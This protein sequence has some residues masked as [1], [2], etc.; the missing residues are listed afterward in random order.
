MFY[1]GEWEAQRPL[2]LDVDVDD[3]DLWRLAEDD[4]DFGR[5]GEADFALFCLDKDDDVFCAADKDI[6]FSTRV[7]DGGRWILD[8]TDDDFPSCGEKDDAPDFAGDND[9][10]F[11][12]EETKKFSGLPEGI[13]SLIAGDCFPCFESSPILIPLI[14]RFLLEN[15]F[16]ETLFLLFC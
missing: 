15:L 8:V 10:N 12:F 9:N 16:L 6:T 1:C 4:P 13:L 3:T 5:F 2:W 14:V 7:G 11:L